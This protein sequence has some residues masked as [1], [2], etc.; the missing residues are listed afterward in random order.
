[1]SIEH[2]ASF[3]GGQLQAAERKPRSPLPNLCVERQRETGE[4]QEPTPSS[5]ANEARGWHT[6]HLNPPN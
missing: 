4:H 3:S 6:F 2:P 5:P 1:M